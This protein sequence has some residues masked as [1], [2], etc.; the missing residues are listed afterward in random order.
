MKSI[1]TFCLVALVALMVM[2]FAGIS[3]A[4][5]GNTALCTADPSGGACATKV[6]HTHE[7][8]LGVGV[9]IWTPVIVPIVCFRLLLADVKSANNLGAPLTLE[10]HFTYSSCNAGCQVTEESTS[11][12]I[13]V[14]RTGHETAAVTNQFEIRVH[15]GFF[16]NCVYNGVGLEGT[17]K[18]PLL[19]TAENG[20]TT[21]SGQE[22]NRVSGFC[23]ETA[24]L[25]E[26]TTPLSAT[27]IGT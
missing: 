8:T 18:G 23:P 19:S 24:E 17:A 15:C 6:T 20:E 22:L 25:E 16:I 3:S 1:K 27:Y 9:L 12:T 7:T 21:S 14:L 5:A 11:D 10:G 13:Q 4:I 2:A 26:T